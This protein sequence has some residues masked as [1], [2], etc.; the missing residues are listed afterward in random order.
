[1]MVVF[2]ADAYKVFATL[3]A[4]WRSLAIFQKNGGANMRINNVFFVKSHTFFSQSP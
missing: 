3:G 2:N 1:M 4:K